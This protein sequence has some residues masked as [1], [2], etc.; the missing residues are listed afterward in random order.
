MNP[1]EQGIV[2]YGRI[3]RWVASPANFSLACDNALRK[4]AGLKGEPASRAE[5]AAFINTRGEELR[6]A[7]ADGSWR[8]GPLRRSRHLLLV[9]TLTD[10]PAFHA[11]LQVLEPLFEKIF[12]PASYRRPGRT[13]AE[14][15][16]REKQYR[17]EARYVL[18]PFLDRFVD[19]VDH[20]LLL[21][22]IKKR[23]NDPKLIEMLG[24][25]LGNRIAE[26]G[27]TVIL[28]R[29]I[30][31]AGSLSALFCNIYLN[32]LDREL[33]REEYRFTRYGDRYR[34]CVGSPGEGRELLEKIGGYLEGKLRLELNR[35]RSLLEG[36]EGTVPVR[37]KAVVVIYRKPRCQPPFAP[38]TQNGD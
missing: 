32:G 9:P 38:G 1:Q 30:R 18:R 13:L 29:G 33:E 25:V 11:F 22:F 12:S 17:K 34:I 4:A 35:E 36:P 37:G 6:A 2:R 5:L 16:E 24:A 14:A 23:I 3:L 21:R 28:D 15:L 10:R 7:L 27:E 8:P 31:Q 19:L 20:P 26:G